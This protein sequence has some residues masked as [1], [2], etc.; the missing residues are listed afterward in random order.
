V[1]ASPR[2]DLASS[3]ETPH[4]FKS[5]PGGLVELHLGFFEGCLGGYE[6]GL[7]KGKGHFAPQAYRSWT[8]AQFLFLCGD[9]ERALRQVAGFLRGIH[10]S[11]ICCNV[12]CELRTS[13]RMVFFCS[14]KLICRC[15]YS[16]AARK[17]VRFENAL[18]QIDLQVHPELVFG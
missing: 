6:R 17:L 15:R 5:C 7:R 1:R 8:G 9:V 13:K 18:A 2:P 3:I 14:S 16:S 12:N 4:Q 10:T 11:L